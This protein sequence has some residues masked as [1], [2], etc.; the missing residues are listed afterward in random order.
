[1]TAYVLASTSVMPLYGKLSD[2]Y[3]RKPMLYVAILLFLA[4]SALSGA[5]TSLPQLI[6]FR[7]VQGLGAG[8]LLPL[9]QIIIG[10]LVPP[11]QRG[12]RQGAIVAVFAVCSVMGP[13]LGGV[14]TEL[15]SWH[16]IFY[17]NLPVGAVAL[18]VIARALRRPQRTR[19]RNID[20]LGAVLLTGAATAFLL[21]LTMGGA[22]WPWASPQ[23]G[24]LG[25]AAAL[26]GLLFVLQ[27]R[28]APEPVLPLELFRDRLFLVACLVLALA[29]MGM[30]G[31]SLFFPL[32]FQ[33][34]MGVRPSRSGFLT[35]P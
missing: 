19:R 32:F 30:M 11:A 24:A 20:Y 27:A 1:M 5:A 9:S 10:D 34:V 22:Q 28:R 17:V 13:M 29:Y 25:A 3:G 35:G 14:I 8:G 12:R 18:L 33:T 16:W 7:V 2:Q 23:V 15:W 4:G 26:L 31:A 21:V 6:A